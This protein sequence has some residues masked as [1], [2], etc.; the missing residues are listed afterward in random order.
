MEDRRTSRPVNE[1]PLAWLSAVSRRLGSSTDPG[2]V[3]NQVME[4]AVRLTG[5]QRGFLVLVDGETGQLDWQAGYRVDRE[6]LAGHEMEI[7]RAVVEQVLAGDEPVLMGSIMGVP[8][9]AGGKITGALCVDRGAPGAIWGQDTLEALSALADQA[10]IAIENARLNRALEAAAEAKA[11]FVS[12]VSHELRVP[13]T[14]IKG[15]ADMLR[16]GAAGPLTDL[17]TSF[18]DTIRRNVDRMSVL[19]TDLS[20]INRIENGRLTPKMEPL[21]LAMLAGEAVAGLQDELAAKQQNV[22]FEV[23]P[24]LE[25]VLGDRSCVVQILANLIR[26]ASQYSPAGRPIVVRAERVEEQG[27][28]WVQLQVIDQGVGI[29]EDDR[30]RLFS[31]FFR[32]E[33]P[34]VRQ[35]PG[36]GLGLTIAKM[37]TEAH[38]GRVS[39]I[40]EPNVGS[41][42]GFTLPVV[43]A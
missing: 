4:A 14:A 31:P 38:G 9:W 35:E 33:D 20:T 43:V 24:D 39:V 37:L 10:A 18:L 41:I 21:D 2:E 3:L 23:A 30:P 5:A 28:A 12:T 16:Q 13:M 36:W 27:R 17:Q 15:Y 7:G 6:T 1:D 32:S 29:S 42:F 11:T 26:N 22:A 19:I 34:K 8:L 25:P 40:S